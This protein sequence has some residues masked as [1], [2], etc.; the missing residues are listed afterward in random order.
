MISIK[1]HPNVP[2]GE[3]VCRAHNSASQ[4]QCQGHEIYPSNHVHSIYPEPLER[5][6]LNFTQTFLSVR[7]CAEPMTQ[8][9]RLNV[10]VTLQGHRI[11]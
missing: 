3:T 4:T 1:H 2:L 9:H 6:S 8:L 11:H 7:R 5:F 10:N